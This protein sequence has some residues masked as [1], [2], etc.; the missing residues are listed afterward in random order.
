LNTV[1][2]ESGHTVYAPFTNLKVHC[3]VHQSSPLNPILSQTNLLH[4]LQ[5]YFFMIY[6]NII[7]PSVCRTSCG[8]FPSDFDNKPICT[9]LSHACHIPAHFIVLLLIALIISGFT[10]CKS[11]KCNITKSSRLTPYFSC[12]WRSSLKY[13]SLH[14]TWQVRVNR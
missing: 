9:Y 8:F 6:L 10:L 12:I 7:P 13:T 1:L 5:P 11:F 3:S 2:T 14:V 4:I